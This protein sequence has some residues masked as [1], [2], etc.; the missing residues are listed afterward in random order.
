MSLKLFSLLLFIWGKPVLAQKFVP[1]DGKQ[2][3]IIGQDLDAIKGYATIKKYPT[4]GGHT[5]Y[6]NLFAVNDSSGQHPYGGLGEDS[7]ERAVPDVDWGAGPVNA[8]TAAF[9]PLYKNSVLVIGLSMNEGGQKFA[10]VQRGESDDE[11]IRLG[12]FIK[13]VGKPVYLRIAY[14][15]EGIWN[16][17]YADPETYKA[18]FRRVTEV[19]RKEDV[20]N[21]ATVWQT[22][23]SPV[24]DIIDKKHENIEDW[25]PG[26][27]VVD[28]MALSWFLNPIYQSPVSEIKTTQGEL[29]EELLAMARTH[30][31][32]VMIAESSPQGYDLKRLT[33]KNI[34]VILDGP[35]GKDPRQLT[36]PQI[37][38]EWFAPFFAFIEKNKD[39]VR[40][41]A[42]INV[43]WD[44]QSM[45]GP[46]YSGG[47][48]GNSQ[49]Q[50][51]KY[52]S[53][54]WKKQITKRNWLHGSVQLFDLLNTGRTTRKKET[55]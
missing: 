15:F 16:P 53:E 22:S 23:A 6:I 5:V 37:W 30:Q 21:F 2:L 27:D 54:Q 43:H 51:N 3:L 10:G 45:W 4:P 12:K 39:I 20:K 52:I 55:R 46:P 25:Y 24:D 26:D 7:N 36:A 47:Y 40:A 33:R 18:A 1:Q 44:A 35:A 50:E 11:I 14:E 9:D 49:V 32:P 28:W 42:Y 19:L 38:E 48:W 17:S 13:K 8:H 29:V 41:V 31:K 34:A